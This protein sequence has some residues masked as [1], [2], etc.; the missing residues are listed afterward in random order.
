[1]ELGCAAFVYETAS[2][3][4]DWKVYGPDL[5]GRFGGLHGT[6]GL[7]ATILDAG[8]T[9]KGVINDQFGNGVASVT[10]STVSW[11]STRSGGYGPLPGVTAE[12]LT[13]ITRLAEATAW[14]SRRIDPTGLYNLGAR[15]YE[16]TSGRFLSP[17]PMGHA[18]SMSLYDFCNGDPVNYFDADGRLMKKTGKLIE[19]GYDNAIQ[20]SGWDSALWQNVTFAT[21]GAAE[22]A[23][24]WVPGVVANKIL[25]AIDHFIWHEQKIIDPQ[26]LMMIQPELMAVNF[27]GVAAASLRTTRGLISEAA[28]YSLV[29]SGDGKGV[30]MLADETGALLPSKIDRAVF[31]AERKAFWKTEAETN[32]ATYNADDVARMQKGSAPIGE[33]GYPMELHHVNRTPEGGVVPM[34]RTD[35][36][37]GDNYK[38]NHPE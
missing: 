5:N 24:T 30:L 1:M 37:L 35:H 3:R 26:L 2:D 15:Y 13:D 34:T 32:A 8:G 17:D 23:S 20:W 25:A 33:D 10:G 21:E 28:N 38:L 29:A 31:K 19:G 6:G 18:A 27:S 14:R 12:V 9:T 11:F 22:G 4:S 7:E 16:P 36:R